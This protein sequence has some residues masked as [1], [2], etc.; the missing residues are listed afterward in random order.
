MLKSKKKNICL[1]IRHHMVCLPALRSL[2]RL[3][4]LILCSC[5]EVTLGVAEL[6]APTSSIDTDNNDDSIQ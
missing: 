1:A 2:C 4:G 6:L 5:L 3:E